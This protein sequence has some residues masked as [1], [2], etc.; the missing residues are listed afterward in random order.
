MQYGIRRRLAVAAA[1]ALTAPLAAC[2]PNAGSST[3]TVTLAVTELDNPFFRELRAG[4]QAAADNAGVRLE[5]VGARNDSDRQ[6]NQLSRAVADG[7]E[8]VLLNAV[9]PESAGSAVRPVLRADIPVVAVDREVEGARVQ[10]TIASDNVDGGLQAAE[11]VASA[12]E[13]TGQVIHLQGDPQA[14]TSIERGQGF[15]DGIAQHPEIDLA[16]RQ[17]A[18]FDRAKARR[19]TRQ[20]L[21]IY[22][23][24]DAIFAENDQMALGA[25]D[26]L[27][28]RAGSEVAVVGYDGSPEALQAVQAGTM[29]ATVAQRPEQMGRVAVEQ[30]ISAIDGGVVA[31]R[32]PVA[33]ELVTIDNVD[34]YL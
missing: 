21:K 11:A 2:A 20:L 1:V 13:G 15:A 5:V 33:V 16:T 6:A 25:V 10:S 23:D 3:E 18:Y 8:A 12:I 9:D 30:A 4:A 19:V 14:S 7:T 32:V 24:A 27:G 31:P 17:P 22:P 29:Q 26:A 34:Q 28:E